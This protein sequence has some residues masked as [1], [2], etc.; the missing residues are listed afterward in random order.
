[1]I[2]RFPGEDDRVTELKL[3]AERHPMFQTE[4]NVSIEEFFDK[5][6]YYD[7]EDFVV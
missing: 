1:M 3:Y 5:Y 4:E 7:D 6:L 2:Q